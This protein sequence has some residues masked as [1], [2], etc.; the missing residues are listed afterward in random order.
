MSLEHGK[1]KDYRG[2]GEP[3]EITLT[4]D[5]GPNRRLT[6]VL[7]D[8]LAGHKIKA[9]FFVVGSLAATDAGKTIMTRIHDEGH[10]DLAPF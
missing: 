7:L 10:F 5:D 4:F 1:V 2:A 6:P 8:V 3:K 9:I